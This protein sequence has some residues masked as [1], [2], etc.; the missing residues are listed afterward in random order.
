MKNINDLK[1]KDANEQQ[2][3][4]GRKTQ[5][6]QQ[7]QEKMFNITNHQRNA[8]QK[9]HKLIVVRMAIMKKNTNN[10]CWQECGEKGTLL[11]R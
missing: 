6:S 4:I 9:G 11:H 10:E 3:V 5:G 8:S 7:A 1:P 2:D